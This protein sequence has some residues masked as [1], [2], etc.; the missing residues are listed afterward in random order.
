M[1]DNKTAIVT[2]ASRGIGAAIAIRLSQNGYNVIVNYARSAK[3]A[4]QVVTQIRSTGGQ[5]QAVQADVSSSADVSQLF[6]Q[7]EQHFGAIDVLVNNAGVLG[8]S[9]IAEVSEDTIHQH[10]DINLKGVMF[11]SQQ[12]VNRLRDGGHIVN[13]ST[14]VVGLKLENYAVYAATKAGVETFSAIMAKELRG[15]DITV[16]TVAPGPTETDL[17]MQGKSEELVEKLRKMPPLERLGQP[18]EI[19]AVV[20]FLCSPDGRWVNGQVIRANGGIV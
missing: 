16:N 9:S 1:N 14:S 8:L 6:D 19:A 12:G 10:V 20:A 13:L 2:G 11:C 7:A 5:A 17:F 15:R 3:E 4:E 18:D